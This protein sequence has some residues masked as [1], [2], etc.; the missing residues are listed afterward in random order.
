M[1]KMMPILRLLFFCIAIFAVSFGA[2]L[3]KDGRLPSQK[4]ETPPTPAAGVTP[5][6]DASATMA[7]GEEA[8]GND[9]IA[10]QRAVAAGRALFDVPSPISIQEASDLMEELGKTRKELAEQK[11]ALDLRQRQLDSFS[12][13]LEKK[14]LAILEIAKKAQTGPAADG[15]GSSVARLDKETATRIATLFASM[16]PQKAAVALE[17]VPAE[18]AAQILMTMKKDEMGQILSLMSSES[19]KRITD[20]VAT[21]PPSSEEDDAG[22]K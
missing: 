22:N 19:L 4:E 12:E 14:R 3:L 17:A 18:R 16:L 1:K 21:L 9:T 2:L 15:S 5:G 8:Q 7:G 13:E 10:R 11:S 20:A 6:A